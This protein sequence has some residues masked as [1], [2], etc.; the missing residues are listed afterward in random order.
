MQII[1]WIQHRSPAEWGVTYLVVVKVLTAIQDAADVEPK[2]LKPP[3]GKIIY[4]LTAVGGYLGLG[5]RPQ[6][7]TGEKK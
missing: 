1:H 6:A 2:N 5:N 4:Y 7:I 3:F